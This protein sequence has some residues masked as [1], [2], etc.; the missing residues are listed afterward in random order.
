M[1]SICRQLGEEDRGLRLSKHHRLSESQWAIR[2]STTGSRN[3][4]Q[5]D[6]DRGRFP[7]N[8]DLCLRGML[9]DSL[10]P[11]KLAH[12]GT[13]L[14]QETTLFLIGNNRITCLRPFSHTKNGLEVWNSKGERWWPMSWPNI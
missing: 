6:R 13:L 11:S 9:A 5:V 7:D 2:G 12:N 14:H 3:R 4:L 10:D 8:H 1:W